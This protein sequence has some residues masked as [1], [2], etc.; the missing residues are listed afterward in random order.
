MFV[1]PSVS[2]CRDDVFVCGVG[3]DD[4][5]RRRRVECVVESDA[6][7]EVKAPAQD[8]G[9][10]AVTRPVNRDRAEPRVSKKSVCTLRKEKKS[11]EEESENNTP[12]INALIEK[13][14]RETENK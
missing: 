11:N 9:R 6:G 13:M 4:D 2:S 5:E 3:S 12:T 14:A 1:L 8:V 7:A 10:A